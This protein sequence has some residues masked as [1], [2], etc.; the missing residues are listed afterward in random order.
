MHLTTEPY[1]HWVADKCSHEPSLSSL[2]FSLL[3][4]GL[5]Q[6]LLALLMIFPLNS[7]GFIAGK[8]CT[9]TH[10]LSHLFHILVTVTQ[11]F[12]NLFT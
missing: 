2:S 11:E 1:P 12:S 8:C 10:V 5:I 7:P 6:S 9:P 4:S 3:Y